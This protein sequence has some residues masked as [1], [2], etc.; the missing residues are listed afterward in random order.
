VP[1]VPKK[2]RNDIPDINFHLSGEDFNFVSDKFGINYSHAYYAS[3]HF[4]DTL[5][6]KIIK[7]LDQLGL[8]ENTIIVF[9]GDQGFHLG[10]HG[11]WHKSTFF[12]Q[13]CKVPLIIVD[14]R[15]NNAGQRCTELAGLIDVYPTLCDL[16]GLKPV[17]KVSGQ[18]LKPQLENINIPGKIFELTQGTPGGY[19]IRT[20]Q[21]RYTEWD[22]DKKDAMCYDLEK[23]PNE[24]NSL[25]NNP[26][27]VQK[28]AE[29]KE[30]L[31]SFIKKKI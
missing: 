30:I 2:D 5:V 12:E 25:V 28:V 19:S 1:N 4:V 22:N 21:Y 7:E 26:H 16:A 27:Y 9:A 18:S 11:H 24:F 23:D 10:E 17:H 6:G 14:P 13:A 20:N 3:V 29:L 15:S 8:S 31:Q